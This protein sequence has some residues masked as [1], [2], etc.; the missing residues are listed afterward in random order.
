M[1]AAIAAHNGFWMD[2]YLQNTLGIGSIFLRSR[3]VVQGFT[4]DLDGMAT[5]DKDFVPKVASA[6]RK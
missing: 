4:D 3:L 5:M 1:A 6:T 2:N